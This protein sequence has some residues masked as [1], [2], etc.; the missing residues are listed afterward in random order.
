MIDACVRRVRATAV[1]GQYSTCPLPA[2]DRSLI[3]IM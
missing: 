1:A 2:L 3:E